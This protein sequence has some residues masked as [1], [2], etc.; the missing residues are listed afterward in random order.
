MK[1]GYPASLR[2]ITS[3][4]E[5]GS[6]DM[7]SKLFY[8]G[9]SFNFL[10]LRETVEGSCVCVCDCLIECCVQGDMELEHFTSLITGCLC[11]LFFFLKILVLW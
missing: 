7:L 10:S 8:T 6:T 2:E 4:V 5:T 1:S 3:L 11:L 9:M